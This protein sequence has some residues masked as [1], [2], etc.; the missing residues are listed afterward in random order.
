MQ[1]LQLYICVCQSYAWNVVGSIFS[2]K[3][4]TAYNERMNR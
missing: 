1:K 4:Y 3:V 2:D